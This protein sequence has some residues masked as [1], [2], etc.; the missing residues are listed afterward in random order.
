AHHELTCARRRTGTVACW[1]RGDATPRDLLRVTDV[2]QLAG[3]FDPC[4]RDHAGAGTCLRAGKAT[5]LAPPRPALHL[6][7]ETTFGCA[8]LADHTVSC[9][10]DNQWGMFGNG[11]TTRGIG[12][13]PPSPAATGL[14]DAIAIATG[15]Y[16]A[17]A[18]RA[19]REVVCWGDRLD[20]TT[21]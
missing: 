15:P 5:R 16:H 14:T 9:W 1:G 4:V 7:P 21:L 6:P 18:I 13:L 19:S 20:D 3:G 10:G 12:D 17:C 8:L 11:A 2:E